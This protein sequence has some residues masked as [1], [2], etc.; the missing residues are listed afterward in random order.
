LVSN[1]TFAPSSCP[2]I[3]LP[4]FGASL[5]FFALFRDN[6][7]L[8]QAKVY[9]QRIG[10]PCQLILARKVDDFF[11]PDSTPP[12]RGPQT[13]ASQNFETQLDDRVE[14]AFNSVTRHNKP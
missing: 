12:S 6:F 11:M 8:F 13:G 2:E 5:P 3:F 4:L 7:F 14:A 9:A 1:G 10:K